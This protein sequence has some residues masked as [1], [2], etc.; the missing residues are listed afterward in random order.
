MQKFEFYTPTKIYFGKGAETKAGELIRQMNKK[1]VMVL[2]GGGSA[3]RNGVLGR[4]E[5]SLKASGIRYIVKGGVHA[6]PYLAFA[7]EALEEARKEKVDFLLGVGGGS[8]LDTAK[9]VALGLANPQDDIWDYYLRKKVPTVSTPVGAVLTIPAAGSETSNSSVLTNQDGNL[10]RSCNLDINRPVFALMNPENTYTLPK[11]QIGCGIVDIMMHTTERYFTQEEGNELTDQLAEAVLRV[12][13]ENGSTAIQDSHNYEAMSE[14]MWAGSLS[15]NGL[16]G[17]GVA[18]T[19][20]SCHQLGHELSAKYD[21]AHGASLSAVWKAW[22]NYVYMT[23]PSRFARYA[24]K[25]WGV[26]ETDD[27]KAARMGIEKTVEYFKSLDMPV[28]LPELNLGELTEED[29]RE[30]SFRCT[31]ENTRRIGAFQVLDMEDVYHIY[32]AANEE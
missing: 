1:S 18:A 8:V 21:V 32:C 31:Y 9:A 24:R 15:H 7:K 3:V 27:V 11:Y 12:T 19:D 28:C 30:L 23:K 29:L 17:L 26:C 4:V 22:A 2:Y 10:K 16:T 25:V 6:N 14:L 5:D 13:I 20:F